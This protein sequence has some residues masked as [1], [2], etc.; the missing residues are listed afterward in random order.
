MAESK[1][2]PAQQAII[3]EVV[4]RLKPAPIKEWL[5][6]K[7]AAKHLHMTAGGLQT[8]RSK[9]TG[10]AYYRPTWRFVR[11]TRDTLDQWLLDCPERRE[12]GNPRKPGDPTPGGAS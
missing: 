12:P 6:T 9:G 10:P 2:D 3:D 4:R 11:Y 5:S 1:F 7:E 8:L